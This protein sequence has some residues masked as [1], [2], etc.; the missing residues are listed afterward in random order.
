VI[1]R[2][3]DQ[4]HG[5]PVQDVTQVFQPFYTTKAH[6]LGLWSR[7]CRRLIDASWRKMWA[8]NNIGDGASFFFSVPIKPRTHTRKYFGLA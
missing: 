2:V 1:F 7:V 5:I 4:G 8:T 3:C 6:G